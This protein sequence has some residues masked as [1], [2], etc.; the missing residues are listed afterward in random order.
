MVRHELAMTCDT[1][2]V[3][4]RSA[5]CVCC[6]AAGQY[7]IPFVQTPYLMSAS[8]FDKYQLP[9]N[10]G[11]MPP[12]NASALAYA[13]EFQA[14]VRDVMLNLPTKAQPHSAIYSSACFKHC[15]ST[16]AWGSF[17]GVKIDNVSLKDYLGLWYFGTSD[18]AQQNDD[19]GQQGSMPPSVSPQRIEACNGFGCGQCHKKHVAPAPPLP[20]SYSMSL[21]PGQ[22]ATRHR[23]LPNARHE[24]RSGLP[25][26]IALVVLS[27][28]G[29]GALVAARKRMEAPVRA[30]SAAG[31]VKE[32]PL[33][34]ASPLL[35]K[36][37]PANK[38][39]PAFETLGDAAAKRAATPPPA[40]PKAAPAA[41]APNPA[42]SAPKLAAPAP[43]PAAPAPAAA[44]PA[45]AAPKPAAAAPP[46]ALPAAGASDADKKATEAKAQAAEAKNTTDEAAA[47]T[48]A[49]V[50]AA[51]EKA[52]EDAQQ[53]AA[54]AAERK[55]AEEAA[56]QAAAVEAAAQAAAEATS[57]KAAKEA[58]AQQI[59]AAAAAAQ[60]VAAAA[61]E[62][63]AEAA[64]AAG[65]GD[66]DDDI[67]RALARAVAEE[68]ESLLQQ[69]ASATPAERAADGPA[70]E[71]DAAASDYKPV[72]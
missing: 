59:A 64:V 10:E 65:G 31:A 47:T 66:S 69:V 57:K 12:Y 53:A 19:T 21:V 17:W 43:K 48:A 45:A 55:A 41:S 50:A 29:V 15:T 51:A 37:P 34:E 33:G 56:A 5:F 25:H 18:P 22:M 4:T 14:A 49:E 44:A 3:L 36:P 39:A 1:R 62:D 68:A 42:A 71:T 70:P 40:K 58:A 11:A 30:R 32:V 27:A 61:V 52:A 72:E 54:A 20:P 7:R 9:Y 63:P 6:S 67:D 46:A 26:I 24:K 8:Q 23:H 2:G 35:R 38:P 16:L 28:I 60:A 13:S